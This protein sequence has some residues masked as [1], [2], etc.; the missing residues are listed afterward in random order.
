MTEKPKTKIPSGM[1]AKLKLHRKKDWR[2]RL[3]RYLSDIRSEPFEYGKHDCALFAAGAIKAITGKDIAKEW[4]G[5][6]SSLEESRKT[7]RE[8]GVRNHINLAK[9][10][11]HKT[12]EPVAGDIAIVNTEEGQ[13]LGVVQGQYIYIPTGRGWGLIPLDRASEFLG[14]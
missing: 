5:K 8:I 14:V 3:S 4:R 11:L 10:L 2:I 12:D 7:L 13:A 6:Y 9:R 1:A